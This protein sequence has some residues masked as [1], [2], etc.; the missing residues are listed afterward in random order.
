[1]PI[2]KAKYNVWDHV[3]W[4]WWYAVIIDKEYKWKEDGWRNYRIEY[5]E[6]IVVTEEE[7][8]N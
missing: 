6:S 7:I 8:T 5:L 2:P 3:W 4:D 1:M